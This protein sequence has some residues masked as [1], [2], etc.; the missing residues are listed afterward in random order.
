MKGRKIL[1]ILL[2]LMGGSVP[3]LFGK[4]FYKQPAKPPY[5]YASLVDSINHLASVFLRTEPDSAQT[6]ITEALEVSRQYDYNAGVARA[7]FLQGNYY[8][9]R[10]QLELAYRTFYESLQLHDAQK[11]KKSVAECYNS[12]GD[13]FRRQKNYSEASRN[14]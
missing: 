8:Q 14:Y 3:P 9:N 1:F 11:D 10:G 5:D 13:V 6:L 12:I 7:L 4:H 2:L